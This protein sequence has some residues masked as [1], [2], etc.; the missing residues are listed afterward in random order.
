[1]DE[2]AVFEMA[3]DIANSAVVAI[4]RGGPEGRWWWERREL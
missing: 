4:A 2:A 1:M 3:E